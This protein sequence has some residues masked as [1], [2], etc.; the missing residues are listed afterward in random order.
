M[1]LVCVG[2][3]RSGSS[4]VLQSLMSAG[5]RTLWRAGSRHCKPSPIW[6]GAVICHGFSLKWVLPAQSTYLLADSDSLQRASAT[7]G[8]VSAEDGE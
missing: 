4:L 8:D 1:L 7:L 2:S 3:S 5:R 6:C